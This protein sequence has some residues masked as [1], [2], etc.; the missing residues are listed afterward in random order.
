MVNSSWAGSVPF[1][2]HYSRGR[3]TGTSWFRNA[4]RKEG[5]IVG[6]EGRRY[7]LRRC[8]HL[9]PGRSRPS[10]DSPDSPHIIWHPKLLMALARLKQLRPGLTGKIQPS[11]FFFFLFCTFASPS[12]LIPYTSCY[13]SSSGRFVVVQLLRGSQQTPHLA[14]LETRNKLLATSPE[15]RIEIAVTAFNRRQASPFRC[16]LRVPGVLGSKLQAAGSPD[17]SASWRLS[18]GMESSCI[19]RV[20]TMTQLS[21][22]G[23]YHN[24]A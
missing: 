22:L 5:C 6:R 11:S 21:T 1:R 8:P 14:G 13:L 24:P 18:S 10:Q 9:S 16:S 7:Y 4:W 17:Q 3:N 12:L 23:R 20:I 19:S 2:D 15:G